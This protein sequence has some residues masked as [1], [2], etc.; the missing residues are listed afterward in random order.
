MPRIKVISIIG[1]GL[2]GGSLG[3]SLKKNRS[4]KKVIG[5]GRR[6]EKLKKALR[7]KAADEV[8]TD[9]L[10][11]VKEADL[12]V[13]CTPVGL[14]APTVKRIL[15]G[16]KEGCI[17]TDVG[18]VKAPIAKEIA[19]MLTGKKI[20]FIGGHP[21]AGSELSGIGNA[22]PQLFKDA[23][24]ILTPGGGTPA[25]ALAEL[26]RLVKGTGARVL[27][28]DPARHDHIVAATS[29]LP[30]LL[31]AGLVLLVGQRG[32]KDKNTADLVAGSFRDMTRIA[33]SEPEIWED[34]FSMNRQEIMGTM[35]EF[36]EVVSKILQ[37]LRTNQ[38]Q[39]LG[40]M[41]G[42][43]KKTRD[44]MFTKDAAAKN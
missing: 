39:E 13:V 37:S 43:A 24:W 30:H 19:E 12:V 14:I 22:R 44:R 17:I 36:H 3:M 32:Q 21:M 15:P 42:R 6:P 40:Q 25:A 38:K 4:V 33:A 9:F 8:T 31:A 2:I 35:T 23:V 11:G 7:L 34:I 28:L 1:M 20:Y 16:L 26:Q 29:H 5:I 41:F 27:K 18:S 10:D